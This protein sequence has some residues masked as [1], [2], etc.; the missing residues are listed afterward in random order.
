M[1]W[2]RTIPL[3][4]LQANAQL[5]VELRIVDVTYHVVQP[6]LKVCPSRLAEVACVFRLGGGLAGLL[7]KRCR[8]HRCTADPENF[9]L[10]VHASHTRQVVEARDQLPLGQIARSPK[11]NQD[12]RISG[13]Q[14]FLRQLLEGTGLDNRRHKSSFYRCSLHGFRIEN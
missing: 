7:A 2:A 13:W 12:T 9:E 10:T 5:R 6:R 14:R 8:T 3:H 4:L 11:D 1:V